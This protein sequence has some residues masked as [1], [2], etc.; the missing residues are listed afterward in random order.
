[1][2][3]CLCYAVCDKQ[4]RRCIQGGATTPEAV[5]DACG[6]G[7]GCGSCHEQIADILEIEGVQSGSSDCPVPAIRLASPYLR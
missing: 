3:V 5:R 2:I 6:A 1:M 7:N 4:V